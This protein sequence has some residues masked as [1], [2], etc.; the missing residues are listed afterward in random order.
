MKLCASEINVSEKRN[1]NVG[2]STAIAVGCFFK[3]FLPATLFKINLSYQT[4]VSLLNV[5]E[6]R[7]H[8]HARKHRLWNGGGE[9]CR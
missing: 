7:T 3:I 9:R 2:E 6:C 8:Y 5:S 4:E 1:L